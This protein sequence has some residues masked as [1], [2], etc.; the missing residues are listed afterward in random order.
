M[1]QGT[2]FQT[3]AE[4]AAERE[5]R[6]EVTK[7]LVQALAREMLEDDRAADGRGVAFFMVRHAAE[8]RGWLTGEEKGRELSFGSQLMRAAGGVGTGAFIS[9]KHKNSNRRKVELFKLPLVDVEDG[10]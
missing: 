1:S 7:R 6:W 5:A 4:Q 2:L 3:D 9:S 10:A 8:H